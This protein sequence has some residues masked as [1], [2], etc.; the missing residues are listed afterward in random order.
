MVP[1][2]VAAVAVVMTILKCDGTA[3]V[4]SPPWEA[5]Y[6][7]EQSSHHSQE[8]HFCSF[9]YMDLQSLHFLK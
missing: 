3:A 6:G 1:L 2:V 8:L 5:L 9:D 7:K 4:A